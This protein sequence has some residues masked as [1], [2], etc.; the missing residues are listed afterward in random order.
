MY[1][2]NLSTDN[3]KKEAI[4]LVDVDNQITYTYTELQNVQLKMDGLR[5]RT[6]R[7]VIGDVDDSDYAVLSMSSSRS[8]ARN[9]S[10]GMVLK[11]TPTVEEVFGPQTN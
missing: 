5:I 6:F 11:E 3:S 9:G 10:V 1:K 4:K 8:S 7:W 2:E